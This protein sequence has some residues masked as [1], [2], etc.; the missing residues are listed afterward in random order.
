MGNGAVDVSGLAEKEWLQAM[1]KVD[2]GSECCTSAFDLMRY[3]RFRRARSGALFSFNFLSK[4]SEFPRDVFNA[5]ALEH[6]SLWGS[7]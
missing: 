3:R 2:N 4:W 7:R 5:T 1:W 6:L